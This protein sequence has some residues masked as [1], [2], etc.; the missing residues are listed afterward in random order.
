KRGEL[1]NPCSTYE[2]MKAE[3][4][5]LKAKVAELEAAGVPESARADLVAPETNWRAAPATAVAD[6]VVKLHDNS[7]RAAAPSPQ[8]PKPVP[9]APVTGLITDSCDE[10]WRPFVGGGPGYDRW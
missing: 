9:P 8:P 7:G 1:F 10:P 6:N 2:G 5:R 4:E 3:V